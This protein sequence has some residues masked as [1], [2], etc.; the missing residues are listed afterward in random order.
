MRPDTATCASLTTAGAWLGAALPWRLSLPTWAAR[1]AGPVAGAAP[2]AGSPVAGNRL[3]GWALSTP[4]VVLAR[5]VCRCRYRGRCPAADPGLLQN[6]RVLA[7]HWW[8]RV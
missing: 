2:T 5:R 3:A 6:C 1:T 4:A 8:A 7:P